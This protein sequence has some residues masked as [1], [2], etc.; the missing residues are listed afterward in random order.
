MS[1]P[2]FVTTGVPTAPG[3]NGKLLPMPNPPLRRAALLTCLLL[4]LLR[5][6]AYPT[7]DPRPREELSAGVEPFTSWPE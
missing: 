5:R 2:P 1:I 4:L 6:R 7:R 3:P